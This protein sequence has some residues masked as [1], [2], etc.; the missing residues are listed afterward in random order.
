MKW[1][2]EKIVFYLFPGEE[3]R[4]NGTEIPTIDTSE[5]ISKVIG[6]EKDSISFE[7]Y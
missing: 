2:S 5:G 6:D 1:N 3:I 7:T 4:V